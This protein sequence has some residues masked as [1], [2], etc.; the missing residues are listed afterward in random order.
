MCTTLFILATGLGIL[1]VAEAGDAPTVTVFAAAS[2]TDAITEINALFE[3]HGLGKAV[4]SFAS[5]STLAKQIQNGAPADLFLSANTN[6]M[7]YLAGHRMIDR[8]KPP[9]VARQPHRIGLPGGQRP[10]GDADRRRIPIG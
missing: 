3:R 5:S 4:A 2:T 8:P 6:W 7:D 1:S 9:G 10:A